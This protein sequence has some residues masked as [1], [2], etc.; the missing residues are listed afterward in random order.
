MRLR[1]TLSLKLTCWANDLSETQSGLLRRIR[2]LFGK[3]DWLFR[4]DQIRCAVYEGPI[5]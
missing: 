3:K 2:S 4:I 1:G 5:P